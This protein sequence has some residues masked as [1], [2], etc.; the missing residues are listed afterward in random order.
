MIP[1]VSRLICLPCLDSDGLAEECRRDL[2]IPRGMAADLGRTAVDL[3]NAGEYFTTTGARVDFGELVRTAQEARKSLPPDAVLPEVPTPLFES[4]QVQVMN[5]TSLQASREM[6]SA[7]KRP[8]ALNFANGISP[9]GGFLHGARAQ[10]EVLCRSSALYLTL[11]S[12][13]MYGAH[14]CRP[15][16]DSTDWAILSPDVPVF[17]DDA[18]NPLD[19]PWTLSFLTCAA[20]YAPLVG[21]SRSAEL[22]QRRIHRT[23]AISRA[24]GY[25]HLVLGAWGCGAF[26][27]DPLRTARDYRAALEGEFAGAFSEIIFAITD[28]SQERRFLGPFRDVFQCPSSES[29]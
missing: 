10:E 3:S 1:P 26:G 25:T 19:D 15:L 27:N 11:N 9:G 16:P 20:P 14:A 29:E 13:P 7:G 5:R 21:A 23:L 4:T 6:V 28:W 22:L 8:L 17:R 12:D 24:Y 2:D 18:G